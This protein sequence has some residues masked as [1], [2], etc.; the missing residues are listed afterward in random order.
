[1]CYVHCYCWPARKQQVVPGTEN[2]TQNPIAWCCHL[3]NFLIILVYY[4]FQYDSYIAVPTV[5]LNPLT[6][7]AKL[8]NNGSLYSYVHDWYTGRWW[9]GTFGTF[10]F[11]TAR[12]AWAG[13][14]PAQSFLAV[15]DVTAHTS[16]ASVPLHII[17]R[18]TIITCAH[19]SIKP[20]KGLMLL[21][22]K[23]S[24]LTYRGEIERGCQTVSRFRHF[25]RA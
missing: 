9:V 11:S 17:R 13:C 18:G 20:I 14:G 22:I 15:P 19:K 23:R 2:R 21:A 24:Y 5:S 3:A 25:C 10:T 1:M 4:E 8:Q 6:G 16:I 12:R 7:T